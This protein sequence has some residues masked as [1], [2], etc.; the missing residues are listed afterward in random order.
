MALVVF[1]EL[2]LVGYSSQDLFHQDA[3]LEAALDGLERVRDATVDLRPVVV[4][5]AP[6]RFGHALFNTAVVFQR[7]EI[8]G[9]VPK[10]Y[11]PNYREFYEKRHFS[12]AR[13]ATFDTVDLFGQRDIAFGTDLLFHARATWTTSSS[14]SRS[15]KTSGC[16]FRRAPSPPWPAPP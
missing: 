8:L 1:P 7:G 11:L 16:R 3:L 10:S 9:I 6:L 12:A 13:Q 5:G 15:A 4:V 14:R 2:G